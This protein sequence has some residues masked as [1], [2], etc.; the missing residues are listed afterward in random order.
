MILS[1]LLQCRALAVLVTFSHY[2]RGLL[3]FKGARLR[4]LS[5]AVTTKSILAAYR[6]RMQSF[7]VALLSRDACMESVLHLGAHLRHT[8][9]YGH[10]KWNIK[11]FE[12]FMIILVYS[13]IQWNLCWL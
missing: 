7:L 6:A 5:V 8:L 3:Q 12:L 11:K 13:V 2:F 1:G 9:L 4:T 10:A